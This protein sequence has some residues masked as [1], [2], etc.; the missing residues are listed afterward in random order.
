MQ[1][2]TKSFQEKVKPRM[3][4]STGEYKPVEPFKDAQQ[5]LRKSTFVKVER[6][7]FFNDAYGDIL[8]DLFTTWLMSEPHAVK[9]REFLYASAMAL[10]EV[11]KRLVGIETY[12]K[13]MKFIEE[14][15]SNE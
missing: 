11:K 1:K 7:Q 5:A 13:N 9:E 10:G 8:S 2:Y 6:E 14:T 3:D 15:L 12:G 4:H